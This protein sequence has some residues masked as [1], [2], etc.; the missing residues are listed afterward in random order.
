[1]LSII[2]LVRTRLRVKEIDNEYKSKVDEGENCRMSSLRLMPASR[3][4]SQICFSALGHRNV[5]AAVPPL[6][7]AESSYLQPK[8]VDTISSY[9][10]NSVRLIC[11]GAPHTDSL[12]Y[13][14]PTHIDTCINLSQELK[15]RPMRKE[16]ATY[17][18]LAT[19]GI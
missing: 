14:Q 19:A 1:M 11:R 4:Q 5:R 13:T 8:I 12:A 17:R 7:L 18:K 2:A 16:A 6:S 10:M 15:V 3:D 9:G